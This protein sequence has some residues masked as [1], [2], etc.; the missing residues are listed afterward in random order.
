M[1]DAIGDDIR[2]QVLNEVCRSLGLMATTYAVVAMTREEVRGFV[3]GLCRAV[4]ECGEF[5]DAREPT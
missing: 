3:G 1:L 2:W 5:S 4:V